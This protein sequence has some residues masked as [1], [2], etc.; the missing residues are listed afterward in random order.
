MD[1]YKYEG[2][3]L[4]PAVI[5][6][7]ATILFAGKTAKRA[8]IAEAAEQHHADHGGAP[9]VAASTKLQTKR[10]LNV[11]ARQNRVRPTGV[12]GLWQF[13]PLPGMDE[14][15]VPA[16]VKE[17][18]NNRRSS[19]IQVERELGQGPQVVYMYSYPEYRRG[20]ERDGRD[21]WPVKIGLS[22]KSDPR[23]RVKEQCKEGA[24]EWPVIHLAIFTDDCSGLEN[25]LKWVLRKQGRQCDTPG[26]EWF[27]ASPTLVTS[28]LQPLLPDIFNAENGSASRGGAGAPGGASKPEPGAVSAGPGAA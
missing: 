18:D 14:L 5:G 23:E 22:E 2:L 4:T 26:V 8:T 20:A 25:M 21:S 16:A 27:D 10:A 24:P 11:L 6:E 3:P 15:P 28:L 9:S 1:P 7:L 19:R 17:T 12:Y 13:P